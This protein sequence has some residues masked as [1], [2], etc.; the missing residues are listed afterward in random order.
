V[1]PKFSGDKD[2]DLEPSVHLSILLIFGLISGSLYLI[3]F[4][5]KYLRYLFA[6]LLMAFQLPAENQ[7]GASPLTK[8]PTFTYIVILLGISIVE[9]ILF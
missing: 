4:S 5:H 9:S 3:N 2:Q 7:A 6:D 1:P 8:G